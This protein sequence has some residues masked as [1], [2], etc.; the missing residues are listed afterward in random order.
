MILRY[1]QKPRHQLYQ[2]AVVVWLGA[3][4][5]S[6]TI[7]EGEKGENERLERPD[8]TGADLVCLFDRHR[9]RLLLVNDNNNDNG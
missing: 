6:R 2:S 1:Y 9:R 4:V 8:Y 7:K 5:R 3:V